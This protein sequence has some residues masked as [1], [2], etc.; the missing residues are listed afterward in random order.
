[1]RSRAADG[2]AGPT[3]PIA[4]RLDGRR[5]RRAGAG[6]RRGHGEPGVR[7]AADEAAASRRRRR[8]GDQDRPA[9]SAQSGPQRAV[10]VRERKKIQEV[11]WGRRM[12]EIKSLDDLKEAWSRLGPAGAVGEQIQTALTLDDVLLV[13]QH[14]TV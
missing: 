6:I 5:R 13:P 11:S 14:C 12:N 8:R 7:R 3:S 1:R 4:A 2:A 9:R 10:S